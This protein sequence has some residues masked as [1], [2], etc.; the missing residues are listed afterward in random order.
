[1]KCIFHQNRW[2]SAGKFLPSDR[3]NVPAGMRSTGRQF[4]AR[5]VT[6]IYHIAYNLQ[7][8]I[9]RIDQQNILTESPLDF[10]N[11]NRKCFGYLVDNCVLITK[12][13]DKIQNDYTNGKIAQIIKEHNFYNEQYEMSETHVIG[14]QSLILVRQLIYF[15]NHY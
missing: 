11:L 12:Q 9:S 6:L 4:H 5:P 14:S 1:M 2:Y 8:N 15:S 13:N 10:L 3:K 7:P